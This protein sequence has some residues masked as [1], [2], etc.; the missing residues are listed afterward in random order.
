MKPYR[1]PQNNKDILKADAKTIFE[2]IRDDQEFSGLREYY[3]NTATDKTVVA[4]GHYSRGADYWV[5][6]EADVHKFSEAS[7]WMDG[8]SWDKF[9][10]YLCGKYE[11]GF[12]NEFWDCLGSRNDI[13]FSPLTVWYLPGLDHEAHSHGMGVYKEYFTSTTD[14]HINSFVKVLKELDEFDNKIFIL[15]A[16]HGM[17]AMPESSQMVIKQKI[18]ESNGNIIG[19]KEWYGENSCELKLDDFNESKNK[20]PE[21]ANNNLH[22]WELARL[23]ELFPT[24]ASGV[25]LKVL[26]PEEI[27][28][29]AKVG[30]T[31]RKETANVIAAL[32]GPM[33]HLYVK[34]S[35]GSWTSEPDIEVTGL[36]L[37]R[38][39][40][41][42]KNGSVA[43][44]NASD[45]INGSFPNLKSSIEA[46]LVR[47]KVGDGYSVITSVSEDAVGNGVL[48]KKAISEY[49]ANDPSYVDAINRLT[50]LND[51]DR[52]GD[53]VLIM[54]D[55]T[56]GEASA[57]YTTGV[58]CKSWH[59]SMNQSDSYVPFVISYPAG[60][61]AE[62]EGITSEACAVS[63]CSGNWM[64]PDIIKQIVGKQYTAN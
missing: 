40:F 10:D 35:D 43:T 64:L 7:K 50:G 57:R 19:S 48:S 26:A 52:S 9:A 29:V 44:G 23:F 21:L 18:R 8:G 51:F 25:D 55:R 62:I 17:T 56:A 39:F 45:K 11:D 38:L 6:W 32:N 33:A 37:N 46:I 15:V 28:E 16:D 63:D 53:I 24:S 41:V 22:I 34:G 58:A 1:T 49:F 31:T 2:Q 12:L 47:E 4:D 20:Y 13:K 30:A 27:I 61:S 36:L 59:G 42:M 60:N 3:Q 54:K 14:D 5:T